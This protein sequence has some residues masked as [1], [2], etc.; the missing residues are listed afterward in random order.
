MKN[1]IQPTQ[2]RKENTRGIL[3]NLG[4][5]I[6][7]ILLFLSTTNSNG[8]NINTLNNNII[9]TLYTVKQL[10]EDFVIL[11][12]A[13]EEGH[14]GLYRYT[15]KAE[16]D[17]MFEK[18]KQSLNK[19]MSEIEFFLK[20]D[21]LI[22]NIHCGHTRMGL[23]SSTI[24]FINKSPIT[25]PFSFEFINKKTYLLYNYSELK[26]LMMGGEVVSIKGNPIDSIVQKMLPL[27]SSD[28]HIQ[29]FKYHY[30]K[31]ANNFSRLYALLYGQSASFSIIYKSPLSSK[32]DTLEIKGISK[33]AMMKI[34]DERYPE[35]SVKSQ[36]ISKRYENGIPVLEIRTF[37]SIEYE[38]SNISY[39]AFL[40]ETFR[41][42]KENGKKNLIIDLRNNDGGEDENGKI[43]A[44]YL[45]DKPFN[46][47]QA[48]EFKNTSYDF[49]K[50]TNISAEEWEG[51]VKGLKKNSNGWYD[52][53]DYPNIGEQ[54]N[55]TPYFNG[56][57]YVLINGNSFS[58]TGE[59]TSIIHFN[60]KAKFVGE[61]CGAAYY[62]SNS[63]IIPLLTLPNTKI[64]ISIPLLKYTMAVDNYPKD[65]GI[66]PDYPFLTDMKDLVNGKDAEMEYLLKLISK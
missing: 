2:H 37:E 57:V 27:I 40:E 48:L 51:L 18:I 17:E 30:L 55:S 54:N 4:L 45:F 61:E 41:E 58:T 39:V 56:N 26:N 35:L 31:K 21:P 62:G 10:K 29:T 34:A 25:I 47:Y 59:L 24:S 19:P 60:K 15:P 63:G 8:E 44:S 49:L 22:A 16:F 9:D 6:L 3:Y 66:I 14:A 12:K 28:A 53:T 20:L 32:E 43:L 52:F 50:Y 33:E 36:P 64:K 7:M 23:S 11:H 65:R 46:Y 5:P 13:L 42:F 1:S 38:E